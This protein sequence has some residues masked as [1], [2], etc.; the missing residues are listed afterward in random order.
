MGERPIIREEELQQVT[1][2]SLHINRS[3]LLQTLYSI[4][5]LRERNRIHKGH[6]GGCRNTFGLPAV[7]NIPPP[8]S[9]IYLGTRPSGEWAVAM[10]AWVDTVFAMHLLSRAWFKGKATAQEG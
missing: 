7:H 5:Q 3:I 2:I 6:P 9:L 1:T 10:N 8:G 4:C